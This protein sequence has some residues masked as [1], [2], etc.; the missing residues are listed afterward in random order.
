MNKKNKQ[1]IN[2]TLTKRQK[3]CLRFFVLGANSSETAK[4]L[5][6]KESTVKKHM[7]NIR[8]IMDAKGKT[9]F[10]I[11]LMLIKIEVLRIKLRL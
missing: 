2:L 9:R 11:M 4:E 7:E 8:I 3:D 10:Q 6:I 1:N 5:G